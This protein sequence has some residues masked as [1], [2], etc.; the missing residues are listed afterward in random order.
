MTTFPADDPGR[1][2]AG[3]LP[4]L[5]PTFAGALLWGAAMGAG[6]LLELAA[7]SWENPQKIRVVAA[8]FALG[9][10]VAFP[11]GVIAAR[12]LSRRRSREAAFA[13]AFLS[14]AA[15][16]ALATGSLFALDYR[17]YYAE[18]H[19]EAFSRVWLLQF[20]HTVAA[21]FYQFAVLGLRLYFPYGFF[22]LLAASFWFA[23]RAR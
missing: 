21:A 5:A 1:R 15:S 11:F 8:F 18:W 3:A 23:R 9:G 19:A 10:F 7:G 13:A 12:F 22:A 4:T 14:L 2:L 16:T 20:A 17:T 6:A